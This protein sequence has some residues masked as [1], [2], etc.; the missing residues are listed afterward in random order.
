MIAKIW[1]DAPQ[2]DGRPAVAVISETERISGTLVVDDWHFNGEDEYPI[3]MMDT[4]NGRVS[5]A[6]ADRFEIS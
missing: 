3:W 2:D 1:P 5:I 4:P 6:H